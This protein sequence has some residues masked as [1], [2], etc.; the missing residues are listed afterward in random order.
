MLFDG[1]KQFATDVV[2]PMSGKYGC[3]DG[4]KIDALISGLTVISRL[5]PRETFGIHDVELLTCALAE[6]GTCFFSKALS[7]AGGLSIVAAAKLEQ[8]TM[9]MAASATRGPSRRSRQ[10]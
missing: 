9:S 3:A 7:T 5:Y 6:T 1:L 4:V 8:S 10:I 2:S